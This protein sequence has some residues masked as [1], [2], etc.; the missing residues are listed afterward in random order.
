LDRDHQ[1][2][3]VQMAERFAAIS[4]PRLFDEDELDSEPERKEQSDAPAHYVQGWDRRTAHDH[5]QW[6]HGFGH[7]AGGQFSKPY[8][9]IQA[10]D[11]LWVVF[12]D[13]GTLHLIG[14]LEVAGRKEYGKRPEPWASDGGVI[15]TQREAEKILGTRDVWP[16]PEHLLARKGTE[17]SFR[18]VAI[19]DRMVKRLEFT[20]GSGAITKV[21]FGPSGRLSGQAFRS[22]RLLTPR[23]AAEFEDLWKSSR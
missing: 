8:Q 21:K 17:T 18:D 16:A 10:G 7:T 4:Q 14:R 2:L 22:V 5:L 20:T 11:V 1:D 3:V 19:P 6:G 15:F 9:P 23:A 13:D 12:V